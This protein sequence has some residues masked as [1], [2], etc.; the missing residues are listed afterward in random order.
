[1]PDRHRSLYEINTRVRLSELSADLGRRAT[2][3]DLP[4]S[5]LDG[6][7]RT[8]FDW[9][10]LL[11]VWQT[12]P[13]GARVAGAN[14]AWR[15]GFRALLPDFQERDIGSS[16]FA[17]QDY[18]VHR[19]FGGKEALARLRERL[20]VRGVR[21]MLDFVPNHTALDHPWVHEHPEFY[22]HGNKED[23]ARQPENYCQIDLTRGAAV[24]A[25][26]RDPHFTGWTDTLQLNYAEPRLQEA[27]RGQLLEIA[28]MCD[29]L[30]CDM[31]MLVLPEVFER[32][33]GL[34]PEP[35][36][37]AATRAVR[38][39]FPDFV[40]MAEVY[41]DLEATLQEQGLDYT[42]DKRLYDHLRERQPRAVR[43]HLRADPGFLRRAVHFLENHDEPRAAAIFEEE[44]HRAAAVLTYLC[45]GLRL[46]HQ[47]Q[48]EGRQKHVPMQLVRGPHELPDASLRQFYA[49]LLRC[50]N[51]PLA[52]DGAWEL[53]ECAPA[54]EGNGAWDHF[55]AFAWR[56][57]DGRALL[58]A[59]N[60][61]PHQGQCFVRLGG[62]HWR[63]RIVL[64][65]D[66]LGPAVYARN[67]DELLTCGLYLDL[68]PW[69]FHV[70][71]V[72]PD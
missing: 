49:D 70:F 43:E 59:V 64:L 2:L 31:A 30:R 10:W 21:L 56:S 26:G 36:W 14:P 16:C 67:G 33:W 45:P 61:A 65:R 32:T 6:L 15:E 55:I 5:E 9:V 29:G 48:L 57:H 58:I 23:L 34:W 46:F 41:W 52:R 51:D 71:D 8:G 53:L 24:L 1:M 66:R 72:T 44:E 63:G 28:G 12:G 20:R 38:E 40:L 62:E 47:G 35:F 11:G 17:V 37:P 22:V 54:W 68:P 3:D 19:D 4:D 7:V 25:H 69:G 27:M 60:D 42:Y 50:V 13:A 39:A 18:T